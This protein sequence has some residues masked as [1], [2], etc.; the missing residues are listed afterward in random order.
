MPAGL[1]FTLSRF[2]FRKIRKGPKFLATFLTAKVM[3]CLCKNGLGY[4]FG[5]FLQTNLVTLP[6]ARSAE[7][8]Q[9]ADGLF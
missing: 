3:Y 8:R 1:L 2:L 9:R 6:T 4:I 5:D 7:R